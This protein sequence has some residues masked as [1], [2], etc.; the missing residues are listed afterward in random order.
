MY[1]SLCADRDLI[2]FFYQRIGKIDSG[3]FKKHLF[4]EFVYYFSSFHAALSAFCDLIQEKC[5][6]RVK[7]WI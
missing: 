6:K 1:L 5:R 7:L 2:L 3:G 4:C